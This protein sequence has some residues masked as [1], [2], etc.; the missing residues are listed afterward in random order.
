MTHPVFRIGVVG[1]GQIAQT[2]HLPALQAS[3]RCQVVA[4]A[5]AD[6]DRARSVADRFHVP[7]TFSCA[8]DLLAG[9]EVD[10]VAVC[11][12]PALHTAITLAALRADKHVFLEKPLVLTHED[13]EALSVAAST[14]RGK[15]MV[16]FNL[17][18][19]RL[20]QRARSWIRQ[21]SLGQIMAAQSVFTVRQS[22]RSASD[23][24]AAAQ[25][26]GDP[27][28]DL[29]THHFD[30]W[31]WLFGSEIV[32]VSASGDDAV[33]VTARL[34]NGIVVTGLFAEGAMEQNDIKIIGSAGRLSVS[35]HRSDG[36]G[37]LPRD[38]YEGSLDHRARQAWRSLLDLPQGLALMRGGGDYGLSYAAEWADCFAVIDG[39]KPLQATVDDGVAATRVALA[40]QESSRLGATVR[41]GTTQ[42][43][44]AASTPGER[45]AAG[46]ALAAIVVIPDAYAAVKRTVAA[47]KRQTA[48]AHLEL[49][50][51][52]R[53]PESAGI[54]E[55]EL[56]GFH[57][58]SIVENAV[59]SIADAYAAGIRRARAPLVALTEDHSFPAPNWAERLIAAHRQPWAA[60]GP[61]FRNANPDSLVSWADFYIA[62]G[63]WAEPAAGGVADFLP[64]HNSCYKREVL[65]ACGDRLEE[66]LDAET[67][68]HWDLKRR[69]L[70]LW[71]EAGTY[72]EHMNFG[73]W[74]SWL[75]AQFYAGRVFAAQRASGWPVGRRALFAAA[76]PL[77]P[78]VRLARVRRFIRRA[79]FARAFR[80]RV[81]GV[82]WIG[83]LLDGVG[84]MLGYA[85][86]AGDARSRFAAYEFHRLRHVK[87]GPSAG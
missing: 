1:L 76:S 25:Q 87:P 71:L 86:G 38:A 32:E 49:V 50:F 63:K 6:T 29:G 43:R 66:L 70:E 15:L 77:I 85:S 33:V 24:R 74:R 83:L 54:D 57:G 10:I 37:F 67:V 51:V 60:V 79:A 34:E 5:D 12:P 68:L 41:I 72:T 17:R 73:L 56:A 65:L 22:R 40:A 16:G 69:G 58:W 64:G 61:A 20:L 39:I 28:F 26:G 84:Q 55:A 27:V 7:Q 31:R 18:W 53:A 46:P 13:C 11:V 44:A 45:A 30:L 14:A 75:P 59:S 21:G 2:R 62:Y 52:A 81:L 80:L 42:P 9:V 78:F 47:L 23:W 82:A 48:A 36:F 35:C 8:E 19:H 4:V 3:S